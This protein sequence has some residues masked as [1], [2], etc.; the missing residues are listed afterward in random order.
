MAGR[1]RSIKPEILEDEIASGL[2]DAAWRLWVSSWLL[3]DDYG[4][5]RA[6]ARYLA[7]QVWQDSAK[8]D[9]AEAALIELAHS[10]L[11]RLY[12]IENQ[13]YGE[14]KPD[15]WRRHQRIERRG[16][17]R[18]PV[19][20]A[21]DYVA[22]SNP[23]PDSSTSNLVSHRA[24]TVSKP[25]ETVAQTEFDGFK[26]SFPQGFD[27]LGDGQTDRE[28]FPQAFRVPNDSAELGPQTDPGEKNR[29][30]RTRAGPPIRTNDHD[31]E[32]PLLSPLGR[33]D[34]KPPVT[35]RS[36]ALAEKQSRRKPKVALPSAWV[37]NDHAHVVGAEC[38]YSK[39]DVDAQAIRFRGDA[40]AHDRR[41][42]DWNQA[43]YNWLRNQRIYD[44]RY[45][46][47]Q[48]RQRYRVQSGDLDVARIEVQQREREREAAERGANGST[49]DDFQL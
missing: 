12:A 4:R 16:Q 40:T 47:S 37:P 45:S 43:F 2:S 32:I 1:I 41:Y 36:I 9:V 38:G 22:Q 30:S 10:G 15:G 23:R 46:P 28:S 42:A 3:A 25:I 24:L 13:R 34:E 49:T 14:I 19:P 39:A 17:P 27:G 20:T 8:R 7:A 26:P 18:V 29:P 21:Q 44:Q 48:S 33:G 11:L 31:Q 6:G 35:Q 5:F